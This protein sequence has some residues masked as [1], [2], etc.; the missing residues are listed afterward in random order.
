MS[1]AA[2]LSISA[3]ASLSKKTNPNTSTSS[4]SSTGFTTL[5]CHQRIIQC[6]TTVDIFILMKDTQ[7]RS[8]PSLLI[9]AVLDPIQDRYMI[10]ASSLIRDRYTIRDYKVLHSGSLDH[11]LL[12]RIAYTLIIFLLAQLNISSVNKAEGKVTFHEL[13]LNSFLL[14]KSKSQEDN[15]MII[16]PLQQSPVSV[17]YFDIIVL[18]KG[19]GMVQDCR[20]D[21]RWKK[22]GMVKGCGEKVF[23]G[24]QMRVA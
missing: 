22:I 19:G 10:S 1:S 15:T 16:A 23:L 20:E 18:V 2:P 21:Q 14:I 12:I 7:Q 8:Y 5:L 11:S 13:N 6:Q 24:L 4:P 17:D 3:V 9:V